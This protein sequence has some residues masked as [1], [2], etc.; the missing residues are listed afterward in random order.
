MIHHYYSG[1]LPWE[2]KLSFTQ[3]LNMNVEMLTAFSLMFF[4]FDL[5]IDIYLLI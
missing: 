1:Q 3:N 5:F 2:M 4:I